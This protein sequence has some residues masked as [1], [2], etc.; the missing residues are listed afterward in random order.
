MGVPD[1]ADLP[2]A[3]VAH[4]EL[5]AQALH[6]FDDGVE[7][8]LGEEQA[9]TRLGEGQEPVDGGALVG[10]KPQVHGLERESLAQPAVLE[11]LA[12]HGVE[13]LVGLDLEQLAK[14]GGVEELVP[15]RE[16]LAD[17][18]IHRQPVLA[19]GLGEEL[20]RA[21]ARAGLQPL[22]LGEELVEGAR[23]V[24]VRAVVPRDPVVGIQL[25]Q[26]EVVLQPAPDRGEQLKELI[27]HQEQGRPRVEAEAARLPHPAAAPE[28]GLLLED[29]DLQALGPQADRRGEPPDPR[30]DDDGG[31]CVQVDLLSL[32]C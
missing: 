31:A 10:R 6:G 1:L 9:H 15:A 19:L 16:V 11:E 32:P 27:D 30:A 4:A 17:E 12:D 5:A 28:P 14:L 21:G 22:H 18:G 8:A 2:V 25:H 29:G 24:E 23:V 20:E 26:L 13:G 3:F 7:P